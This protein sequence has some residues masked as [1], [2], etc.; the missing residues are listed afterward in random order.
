M[1]FWSRPRNLVILGGVL[2]GAA[3]IPTPGSKTTNVFETQGT[4]NIGARWSAAGGSDVHTPGV[5][6][7]RGSAENTQEKQ[8]GP[9]GINT[10]HFKENQASQR[11]GEPGPFDKAWNKAHYGTEKGK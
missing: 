3:F 8:D 2:V 6:T 9:S 11:P 1:S 4:K 5:A 10:E 7:T